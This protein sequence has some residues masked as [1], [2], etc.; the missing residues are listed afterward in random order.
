[1][2][3]YFAIHFQNLAHELE[4]IKKKGHTQT[5]IRIASFEGSGDQLYFAHI[6]IPA[7]THFR[8]G[9]VLDVK[10]TGPNADDKD[11]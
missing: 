9:S 8:A 3:E 7:D 6:I 5:I 1:V 10:L 11:D 4:G 2:E